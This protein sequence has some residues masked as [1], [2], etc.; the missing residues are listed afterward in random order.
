MATLQLLARS[1]FPHLHVLVNLCILHDPISHLIRTF[2]KLFS[3]RH[4]SS[5]S[6]SQA[7][8]RCSSASP[9]PP[10]A[11]KSRTCK[12]RQVHGALQWAVR[13]MRGQQFSSMH[14]GR[15]KKGGAWAL[16]GTSIRMG[17]PWDEKW[18]PT[19]VALSSLR[20]PSPTRTR[21]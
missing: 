12:S 2:L 20:G 10:S 21:E 19:R 4:C 9:S 3:Q 6:W 14:E 1:R 15:K 18:T 11:E 13:G 8:I 5:L 7:R 16:H 17:M